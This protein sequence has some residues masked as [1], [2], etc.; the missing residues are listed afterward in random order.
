MSACVSV[1]VCLCT[2]VCMCACMCVR[3]DLEGKGYSRMHLNQ[4]NLATYWLKVADFDTYTQKILP[5]V[6]KSINHDPIHN[7]CLGLF[8]KGIN[9][10][11]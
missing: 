1:P 2:C 10:I 9:L 7:L 4:H 5:Q 6:I 11:P 8:G 3:A